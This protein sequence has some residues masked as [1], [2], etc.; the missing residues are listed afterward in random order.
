MASPPLINTDHTDQKRESS[1]FAFQIR[2]ISAIP[3]ISA[4]LT[5]L[6]V[7]AILALPVILAFAAIALSDPRFPRESAVRLWHDL[8][9]SVRSA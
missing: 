5:I 4:V 2:A 3:G 6:A 8:R 1:G 9:K 7:P